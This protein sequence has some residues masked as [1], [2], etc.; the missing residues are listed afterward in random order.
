VHE[1]PFKT[2]PRYEKLA[3]DLH[4][5]YSRRID[6]QHRFVY[7]VIANEKNLTDENDERYQGIVKVVRMW[8]HFE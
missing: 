4:G 7:E 6:V 2:P 1:N 3:G 5:Y 8:T